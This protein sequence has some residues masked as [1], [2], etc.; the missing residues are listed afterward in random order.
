MPRRSVLTR[1]STV[2]KAQRV[3]QQDMG[4]DSKQEATQIEMKEIKGSKLKE[5]DDDVFAGNANDKYVE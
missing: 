5:D 1:A 4:D 2:Q 3:A